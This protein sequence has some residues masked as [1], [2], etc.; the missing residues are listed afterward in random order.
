MGRVYDTVSS[1]HFMVLGKG[2][3]EIISGK[4]SPRILVVSR[5]GSVISAQRYRPLG[6]SLICKF[7]TEIPAFSANF[8]AAIV[9]F[10]S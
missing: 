10:P 9:G 8:S 3:D 1:P 4:A 2:M 5:A 6:V 7:S